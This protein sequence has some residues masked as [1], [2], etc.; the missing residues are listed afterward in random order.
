MST[1]HRSRGDERVSFVLWALVGAGACL[2]VLGIL[3]IGIFVAP[4]VVA[5]AWLLLRTRGADRSVVGAVSGVSLMLFFVAWENR[6]GPG[7]VCTVH[8]SSTECAERWNPWPWLVVGLVFLSTG[9]TGFYLL[10]RR[11][12]VDEVRGSGAPGAP[13]PRTS[14]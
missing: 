7:V 14:A 5:L 10:G 1:T 4:V 3:T 6:E 9:V 8:A 2:A 12:L 13:D 11:R